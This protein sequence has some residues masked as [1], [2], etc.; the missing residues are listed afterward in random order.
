VEEECGGGV[1][2]SVEEECGGGV[3]RSVEEECGGGVR[4]NEEEQ[5][6]HSLTYV[7]IICNDVTRACSNT[8]RRNLLASHFLACLHVCD[9][10]EGLILAY[11]D[12]LFDLTSVC[13]KST[14]VL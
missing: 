4:R 8:I 10:I 5:W 12:W 11:Y 3:R 2:R 1:R 14:S 13:I 7:I 6:C 9:T